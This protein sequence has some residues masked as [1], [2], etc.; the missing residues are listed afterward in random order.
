MR[1]SRPVLINGTLGIVIAAA[2]AGGFLVLNP[3]AASGSD[4]TQLTTTVQQGAVSRTISASGS[5]S[6][7]RELVVDFAV[8]GTISSVKV[9]VGDTVKKGTR[10]GKLETGDLQDAVDAAYSA[11]T[12]ASDDTKSTTWDAYESAKDDLASAV[13]KSPISG[14]VVAV[15]GE[16]GGKST[17]TGTSTAS[18]DGSGSGLVT[19][20]DVSA[21]LV[22]ANIAEADIADVALGQKATVTFPALT[23]TTA[24]ATVTAIAPTATESNSIVTYAT[25]ITLDDIPEGLRLG[26][27]AEVAITLESSADDALYVPAA[28]ITTAADGTSTVDVVD[29]SGKTTTVTVVTGIVGDAGTEI[30]SGLT[31]GQ[32][33]VLGI[34][35]PDDSSDS[36]SNNQGPQFSNGGTFPGGT[37]P[38]GGGPN[39]QFGGK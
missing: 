10:L 1:L 12:H 39:V 28:A 11:Y 9:A 5:I 32:T 27:T 22:T 36:G 6:P 26:A 20:A 18:S 16:K 7:K 3:P 30:V 33:V 38:A 13:L 21:Y 8:P 23:D 37:F 31:A 2:A 24:Q 14:L 34:V 25:T 17:G 4:S 19:I 35:T 29:D 15:S